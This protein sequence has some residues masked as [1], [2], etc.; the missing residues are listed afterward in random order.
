MAAQVV[1]I[2]AEAGCTV[3]RQTLLTQTLPA[4]Q[5][6]RHPLPFPGGCVPRTYGVVVSAL[7]LATHPTCTVILR[8]V[9]VMSK[10]AIL[11]DVGVDA[12]ILPFVG[13]L[14]HLL[15]LLHLHPHRELP[16]RE[17]AVRL[18]RET[19]VREEPGPTKEEHVPVE[20]ASIALFPAFVSSRRSHAIWP[21]TIVVMEWC[22]K[23]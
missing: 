7:V 6:L 21:Q 2:A 11:L 20:L 22:A 10:R 18:L 15:H 19:L 16:V 23:R 12:R 13:Q 5:L 4:A 1:S 8:G 3:I 14:L 17:P 9:H